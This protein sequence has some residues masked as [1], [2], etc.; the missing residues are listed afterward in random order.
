MQCILGNFK[1]CGEHDFVYNYLLYFEGIWN[2][3][4]D[5]QQ[6]NMQA[7]FTTF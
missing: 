3:Y 7:K 2:N 6:K 4:A 1:Y 5:K